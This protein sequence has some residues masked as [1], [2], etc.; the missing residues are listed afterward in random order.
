MNFTTG[1]TTT[2]SETTY[3]F[4][5]LLGLIRQAQS[6]ET[7]IKILTSGYKVLKRPFVRKFTSNI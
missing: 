4:S 1:P 6:G 5:F 7:T 3:D 2:A